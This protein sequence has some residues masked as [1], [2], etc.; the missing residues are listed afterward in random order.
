MDH[1]HDPFAP[2]DYDDDPGPARPAGSIN[3]E[4][5]LDSYA[6]LDH[7]MDDDDD[8]NGYVPIDLTEIAR[9]EMERLGVDHGMFLSWR[10]LSYYTKNEVCSSPPTFTN[11][12]YRLLT[13]WVNRPQ[14][15]VK[16]LSNASGFVK[17]GML[18]ALLG[19]PGSGKTTLLEVLAGK[20]PKL[21]K[22]RRG[23]VQVNGQPW[24][25]D[26]NRVAGFV[27]Q[28]DYHIPT[29]TVRETMRISSYLRN[30]P[31][32]GRTNM[33]ERVEIFLKVL[34]LDHVADTIV[35][36]EMIRGVSGG[37][38]KRVSVG[39]ELVRGPAILFLDEPTTGLDASAAMDVMVA[40][41][42]LADVG[43]PVVCSLLQPS[44]ELFETCTHVNLMSDRSC[45]YF[46][47]REDALEHFAGAGFHCPE[48]KNVAEFLLDLCTPNAKKYYSGESGE[49]P[50]LLEYYMGSAAYETVG[51]Q[52]WQKVRPERGSSIVGLRSDYGV[53]Q[54][55]LREQLRVCM[56]RAFKATVRNRKMITARLIRVIVMGL[57][58]GL[59][60]FYLNPTDPDQADANNRVSLIFF[61]ITFTAMGSVAA[62]PEVFVERD[63]F[64]HQ[65]SLHFFR[66]FAYWFSSVLVDIPLSI[67]ETIIFITV[68]YWMTFM[69]YFDFGLHYLF[70][71]VVIFATNMAAKQFCRLSASCLPT[72][73]LASSIAP[74]ILCIW[75]VFAGFLIPRQTIPWY[76][77]WLNV[78][79]PFR[80][81]FESL[82]ISE[83]SG[84]EFTCE[85]AEL[86]PPLDGY[87]GPPYY[88]SQTCPIQQGADVL[89]QYGL[90]TSPWA[91]LAD[92]ALLFGFWFLFC[93]L[94]YLC[95]ENIRFHGR[96]NPLQTSEEK[97]LQVVAEA[98]AGKIFTPDQI[99]STGMTTLDDDAPPLPPRSGSH[100]AFRELSYTVFKPE[101]KL[102]NGVNGKCPPGIMVAL[103]GASGAGKS[104]L[105]D[106]LAGRK[107]GGRIE[108][109]IFLNG[110][111]KDEFFARQNGY[112]EQTN[113]FLPTLTVRETISFSANMR[114]NQDIP[115]EE[116]E[117]RVDEIMEQLGLYDLR[118]TLVG[119][120]TSGISPE[121]RKKL[122]I[123][124]E[125]VADPTVLFLDEPTSGLDSMAAE[126]VM[127]ISRR[128]ADS[129]VAVIC[130]IHQPSSSL[131]FL[132][133][134]LL[135]MKPG[136]HLIYFGNI[137]VD[138]ND[139]ISYFKSHG[140][141]IKSHTNPAD[142]VLECSGAGVGRGTGGWD[143]AE[144]WRNDPMARAL[145]ENLR[146]L[147][148]ETSELAANAPKF[149]SPYAVGGLQ[150]VLQ[151]QMRAL[152]TKYRLPVATRSY[153]LMYLF[154]ALILGSLFWQLDFSTTG[155]RNRV[156]LIFFTIVFAGLGA[157]ASIPSLFEQRSVFYREK[158]AFL[159]PI[160][161][162][163][164]IFTA[165]IPL[166]FVSSV[167]F[168]VILYMMA[169]VNWGSVFNGE[170]DFV[171]GAFFVYL[172]IYVTANLCCMAYAMMIAALA[173]TAALA[174]QI[175]GVSMSVFAL[176][177]GFMIPRDSIP[178]YFWPLHYIDFYKYALEGMTID[179]MVGIDFNCTTDDEYVQVPVTNPYTNETYDVAYCQVSNGSQFISGRFDMNTSQ[180]W[181]W[182]D[183]A[184]TLSFF[185]TFVIVTYL[186]IR[187]VNHLKR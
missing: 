150:Q 65:H 108:G 126:N 52:L 100:L 41:R 70:Y 49:P 114:L 155:A 133:D 175:V 80:Y 6:E 129:G 159:R 30:H 36:G 63:I 21:S 89:A 148:A 13:F 45:V 40:L 60:F 102:L 14:V 140:R 185:I 113:V 168:A 72:M 81:T 29:M 166:V 92:M 164:S 103:M 170:S 165:E 39:V 123:A 31:D 169:L 138:A 163:V 158:P 22:R 143:P 91:G 125:L 136:G 152:K 110:Y 33:E 106:V 187:F 42:Q 28:E 120:P 67:V 56:D 144:A 11:N 79:T 5:P 98:Q 115:K 131:F 47:R 99:T 167:M 122:S 18:V 83:L 94:S 38:R 61:C 90:F 48:Q 145:D 62:I 149:A 181:M 135:L 37:E 64:Y 74:G 3:A 44:Q 173:P 32:V 9:R 117:R 116:R 137:G 4:T 76:W 142:F 160:A 35:G 1:E 162:F 57:L 25:K 86:V 119:P 183:A 146:N 24:T 93:L 130:T 179:K 184:I 51:Q 87:T 34:G 132:F 55:G 176:F 95:L 84:I 156:S 75:L 53:Y 134:W 8:E 66:P 71:L 127:R 26:F 178:Y 58:L 23:E 27:T 17:P 141:S 180:G 118:D 20:K 54:Q 77:K 182:G 78:I 161:Y 147:H 112:V 157:V 177:A 186:G 88:G 2:P 50:G 15:K 139:V 59:L 82:C 46:G 105:L 172:L 128:V 97:R 19:P 124:V 101:K 69:N 111:L 153:V 154:M 73:Q 171:W 151:C 16:L 107:T 12:M 43:I 109:E 10:N 104:T 68:I 121:Q 7:G 174:N 96:R 85:T